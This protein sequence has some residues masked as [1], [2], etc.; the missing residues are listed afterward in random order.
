MGL[1]LSLEL[2]IRQSFDKGDT[3]EDVKKIVETSSKIR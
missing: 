1:D 3:I 2:E